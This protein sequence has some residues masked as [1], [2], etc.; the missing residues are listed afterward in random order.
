MDPNDRARGSGTRPRRSGAGNTIKGPHSALTDYL[1]E[2]GASEHFRERR[3]AGGEAARQRAERQRAEGEA[4]AEVE[5]EAETETGRQAEDSAD[6]ALA[7]DLHLEEERAR[8][9]GAESSR[10]AAESVAVA[11]ESVAVPAGKGKRVAPARKTAKKKKKKQDSD[12]ELDEGLNRGSARKGGRMRECAACGR[13]FLRRGAG[14]EGEEGEGV[15]PQCVRSRDRGAAPK[16]SAPRPS[17]PK[18]SGPS[19]RPRLKKA[20]GG[21]LE[22]DARLTSLQDL[23]VR[24]I[25]QHVDRVDSLGDVSA[26]SLRRLCRIVS[27]MRVLDARTLGLFLGAER[28]AVELFDCTRLDAAA[29]RRIVAEAPRVQALALDFCG[30]LDGAVLAAFAAGLRDLTRLR[31][32][33]AF[34]VRDAAWAG[35]FR[36]AGPRLRAVHVRFAGFGAAAMRALVTHCLA[37]ED[38]RVSECTDF[39]DDCLALL[40]PPLTDAEEERQELERAERVRRIAGSPPITVPPTT[41]PPWRPLAR[42]Q[43][44]DL[45]RPHRAMASQTAQRVVRTL[46]AQLRLLDLSGFRDVDD[47][48]VAHAVAP[49]CTALHELALAECNAV[50][51]PAMAALFAAQGAGLLTRLDLGRCYMLTDAVVRAAVRHSGATLR[52]L[53]LNSVDDNLTRDGL[54]ALSEARCPALEHLDLSWVRCTSDAV[55][56]ALL[57]ACRRLE[58]VVVYGCPDVTRFAPMRPGLQYVGR[59]SDTL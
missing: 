47:A 45:A 23:C 18:P 14:E 35:F 40:A 46:G 12:S 55:L 37:L 57:P 5:A 15:C 7:R 43:R 6:A 25:A 54:L 59:I 9:G 19:R 13:R 49:H 11:V 28:T 10:M 42:L 2:I 17:A 52:S 8:R 56:E 20:A 29:L 26:P 24:A 30:R 50:S 51:P 53:T 39:D 31:L 38:L 16:P 41:A 36:D 32:D 34:L 48:F 44:L 1:Q 33:G 21:L 3:R 22:A 58:R 27:K 4:E